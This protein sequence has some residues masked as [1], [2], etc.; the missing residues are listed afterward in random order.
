MTVYGTPDQQLLHYTAALQYPDGEADWAN[1]LNVADVLFC[2]FGSQRHERGTKR[3]VIIVADLKGET[4]THQQ[5]TIRLND[6][7]WI[8]DKRTSKAHDG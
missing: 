4:P 5:L 8:G 3:L 6:C 1:R 7:M 2:S